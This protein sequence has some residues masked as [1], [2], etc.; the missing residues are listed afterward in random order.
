MAG[1]ATKNGLSAGRPCALV[2]PGGGARAAY[3]AGVVKAIAKLTPRPDNP[4]PVIT[5]TSA[6]AINA[7]QLASRAADFHDG[8][9]RLADIWTNLT[10]EQVFRADKRAMVTTMARW[11][12][13]LVQGGSG[14]HVPRALLDNAPLGV[15]LDNNI[16]FAGIDHAVASGAL[17]ALAIT[18]SGYSSARSVTFFTGRREIGPW[19]RERRVGR[20]ATIE[21]QHI[22]ASIALPTIFPS[23]ALGD[24]YFGDG[25]MRQDAPLSPAIHL[26][27]RKLLVVAVRNE[28]PN[29]VPK[30]ARG[31]KYPTF[32]EIAGYV[33]DTLFMDS[34]YSDL[35][36]LMRINQTYAHLP[37][38]ARDAELPNLHTIDTLVI[39]PSRDIRDIAERHRNEFPHSVNVMLKR[40]GAHRSD[41]NQL[42]SY[43][44]FSGA[45]SRELVELGYRDAMAQQIRIRDFLGAD[46]K[47]DKA[48]MPDRVYSRS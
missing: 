19:N 2:L 26:G 15:L 3:Q 10:V 13:T 11:L 46:A 5:G 9:A 29:E 42:V 21:L 7:A 14:R 23:V 25:S 35:E 4:F 40:L 31:P 12:W 16:D 45:F 32:G 47:S 20:R 24:E 8:A 18:A 48:S 44:L 30:L 6:G 17:T 33:L 43:L 22:M 41:G 28:E 34:L 27:A 36:R 37:A 1:E 38:E 39:T